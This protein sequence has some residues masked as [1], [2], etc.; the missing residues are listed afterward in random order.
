VGIDATHHTYLDAGRIAAGEGIAAVALH[1][2]TAAQ[3][4]GGQADWSAIARLKEAID[5]PVLGNGDIWEAADALRMVRE[6]GCDGVVVGRGCLGRPWLFADLAAAIAG[7]KSRVLP[8]L[9]EV[10]ATMLRHA[11]LLQEHMG[12]ER[13]I[14]DFR[15]HVAWYLKGFA[16]GGTTRAALASVDSLEVL[17][18]LLDTLSDEPYPSA[19]LGAPR[20][21]TTSARPVALPEGWLADPDSCAVPFAAELEHSGG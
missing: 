12:P 17:R 6:T 11:A 9:R 21:R 16:V 15:K 1:A 2:R 5:V 14:R 3:L 18:S 13:G 7:G 4:Y 20:G 10:A 19:V 8:S